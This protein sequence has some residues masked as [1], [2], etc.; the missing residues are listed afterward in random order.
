MFVTAH[1]KPVGRMK[2]V[3]MDNQKRKRKKSSGRC[4]V[5]KCTIYY[6]FFKQYLLVISNKA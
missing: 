5:L 1:K 4:D 2:D 3:W 6:C